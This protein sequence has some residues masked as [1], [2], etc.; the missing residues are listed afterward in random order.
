MVRD[1]PEVPYCRSPFKNAAFLNGLR[2]YGTSGE[3]LTMGS[4]VNTFLRFY[5]LSSIRVTAAG[6]TIETGH[7]IYNRPLTFF[8]FLNAPLSISYASGAGS[9][10]IDQGGEAVRIEAHK[11]LYDF[12]IVELDYH[13]EDD[14][15]R[16]G[17]T[18]RTVGTLNPGSPLLV[19]LLIAETIP[20]RGVVFRDGDVT[21]G[22]RIQWSGK[23]G[24]LSF[25]GNQ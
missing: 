21:Y 24:S 19:T 1:S 7:N 15:I 14:S 5:D 6:K 23:D 3:S 11:T 9:A 12:R 2:Q 17:K 22:Y 20:S 16:V 18:L 25:Q 10:V 4:L 8:T 13:P